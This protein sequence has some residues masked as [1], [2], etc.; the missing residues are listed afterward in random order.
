MGHGCMMPKG[1]IQGGTN[2]ARVEW[3]K[4]VGEG[5]RER[6]REQMGGERR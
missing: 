4:E 3:K 2:I 1:A 5:E 6:E